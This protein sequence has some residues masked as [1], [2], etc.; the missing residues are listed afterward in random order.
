MCKLS[1]SANSLYVALNLFTYITKGII[2]PYGQLCLFSNINSAAYTL[3]ISAP[4]A[5]NFFSIET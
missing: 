5:F 2:Y 1:F 3:S 4:K